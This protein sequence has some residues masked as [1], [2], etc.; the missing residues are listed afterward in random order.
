MNIARPFWNKTVNAVC[1][2]DA[3]DTATVQVVVTGSTKTVDISADN[4]VN[5]FSGSLIN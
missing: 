4:T 5:Q 3:G 2:M 1:D